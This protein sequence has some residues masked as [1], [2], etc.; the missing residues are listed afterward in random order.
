M[1]GHENKEALEI[2]VDVVSLIDLNLNHESV[3]DFKKTGN[4]QFKAD[5][6]TLD[7]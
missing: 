7:I 2:H 5:G 4:Y 3:E 1:I 6:K